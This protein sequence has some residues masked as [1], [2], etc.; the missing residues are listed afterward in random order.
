MAHDAGR[1]L[2]LGFEGT[3]LTPELARFLAGI[4]PGGVILLPRNIEAEP[5][6]RELVAA[7]RRLL[8]GVTLY[9]DAEGG[10]VDRLRSVA[11]PAPSAEQL[12]RV[13]AELARRAGRWVGAALRSFDFDVDLAPV[14]DLDH[15][16]RGNGLD[17][18]YLGSSPRGVVARARGFLA[19]LAASGVGGCLKHFPGLGRSGEDTHHEG[20]R[21]TGD[22]RRLAADLLPFR[23]LAA[24]AGAVMVSHATC[25]DLDPSG[26][27]ASLSS[28]LCRDLLRDRLGFAGLALSDDLDM[29]AL[30]PWGSA[31]ER[32]EA[33]FAAGCDGV[34]LCWSPTAASEAV[35]RLAQPALAARRREAA[36]RL[37]AYRRKLQ[38]LRQ[39]GRGV[40]IAEVRRRLA[41]LGAA[42]ERA[43]VA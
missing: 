22:A 16:H 19:G 9:L 8:P 33:S 1:F 11:A 41:A 6:L 18:R 30:A 38:R 37:D 12:A 20:T 27:P 14:V 10:R 15:G 40:G 2:I 36:E 32:A 31:A 43:T 35:E 21:I 3:S 5:Q 39:E 29:N 24:A 34:F 26:R 25:P 28:G 13:P 7:L 42:V 17:G 4:Q 23:T